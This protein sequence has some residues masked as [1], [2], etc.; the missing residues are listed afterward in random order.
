MTVM[1]RHRISFAVA[2][3][4]LATMYISGLS[5]LVWRTLPPLLVLG[6]TGSLALAVSW[7]RDVI[8]TL[9]PLM[10][11]LGFALSLLVEFV[12]LAGDVGRMNTVFK[13]YYQVWVFF[14]LASALALPAILAA[15][16]TWK[17]RTRFVWGGFF[18]VLVALSALY[19]LTGTPQKIRDRFVA[20]PP[21]LDGLAFADKAEYSLR[22]KSFRL[23]PDLLAIRW[24][25]DHVTGSPVLLEMNT[26]RTLYSWGSR[27][28]T[29]TGLPSLAGWSWHQRQQQAGV[30]DNHVDDRIAD[31]QRIYATTDVEEA[32]RLLNR[33]GVQ[34]IVVG[35]VERIFAPAEGLAK[36]DQM[37]LEKIYDIEGVAIYR[38]PR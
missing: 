27:F 28:S 9:A 3:V 6:F 19:P 30:R 23:R 2:G 32:R 31:V 14:A 34:L 37:G 4:V 18:G 15:R 38:V 12:V 21:T 24:L 16:A 5:L 22:G 1:A 13:F 33:Y 29:H 11:A 7:R 26:D 20:I 35:E 36:F 17:R 8:R 25:Q 10:A